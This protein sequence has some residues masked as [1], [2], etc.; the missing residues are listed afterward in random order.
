[1]KYLCLLVPFL[2]FAQTPVTTYYD[3]G[4]ILSRYFVKNNTLDSTFTQYYKNGKIQ[5]KMQY[6]K[7]EYDTNYI[8][9]LQS[10]IRCVSV[11]Y[12]LK[13]KV[14]EGRKHGKWTF[15]Y[16]D[17]SLKFVSNYHC[18][19]KQG[20]FI[21][22]RTDG[23][24]KHSE[25]YH[26]GSLITEREYH[27]NGTLKILIQYTYV[28]DENKDSGR[29]VVSYTKTEFRDDSTIKSIKRVTDSDSSNEKGIYKEYYPNGFL[30]I[31]EELVNDFREGVYKEFYDNGHKKYEGEY[32]DEERVKKH[33]YYDRAGE[34]TKIESW[35]KDRL[36]NTEYKK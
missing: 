31:S 16:K 2:V 7:C 19:F 30:K 12:N 35:D 24:L 21:T 28:Y 8:K 32:I 20:N 4:E 13:N 36:I 27:E 18:G 17:G 3:S 34:M 26:E 23:I 14:L 10:K 5:S 29:E 33:H 1:M 6:K 11:Y 9:M 22:Y 15:Y 25:F